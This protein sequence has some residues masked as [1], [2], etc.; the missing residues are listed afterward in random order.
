M[1]YSEAVLSNSTRK[2]LSFE[3]TKMLIA[4]LKIKFVV[5]FITVFGTLSFSAAP[6]FLLSVVSA[7]GPVVKRR[8]LG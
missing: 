5:L 8:H 7:V 4:V 1:K 6:T 3:I 2:L